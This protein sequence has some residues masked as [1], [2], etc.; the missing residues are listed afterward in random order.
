MSKKNDFSTQMEKQLKKIGT[1][2]LIVIVLFVSI[3][4]LS[5]FYVIGPD[6]E[7]VILRFGKYVS[8]KQS[9]M[10]WHFPAPIE[11][12]VKVKVKKRH[13]IEIGFVTV[14]EGTRNTPAQDRP[15][16]KEAIMLTGDENIVNVDA[17]VNYEISNA[18]DYLFN[19]YD[20]PKVIKATAESALRQVIGSTVLDDV[21]TEGKHEI[22]RKTK[23]KI[24]EI[25][26]RY[27]CGIIISDFQLQDV[28][29]PKQV[30]DAFKDVASAR[31]DKDKYQK[32]AEGYKNDVIPK[33]KG[34]ASK[35]VNEALAYKVKRVEEAKGEVARFEKMLETYKLGK[36]VTR[37]RLYLE[38]LEKVMPDIDKTIVDKDIK[39][40]VLNILNKEGGTK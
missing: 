32:E 40:G 25:I 19:V 23:E 10:N 15:V 20:V 31:E 28:S 26:D 14:S 33:A 1:A 6:E 27:N 3:W 4:F 12:A 36:D 21:L 29:P 39:N 34:E 18:K 35:L 5:G 17:V 37:T 38:T 22:Q 9:G 8:T 11:N 30:L 13:I 7:A 24:Q 16:Y 2:I